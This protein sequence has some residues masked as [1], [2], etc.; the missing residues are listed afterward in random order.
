M[1]ALKGGPDF[2][3]WTGACVVAVIC[4]GLLFLISGCATRSDM[5]DKTAGQLSIA[6]GRQLNK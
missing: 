3:G 4:V 2:T 1:N 6:L 5:S